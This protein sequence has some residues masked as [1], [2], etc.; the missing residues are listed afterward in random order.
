M[1]LVVLVGQDDTNLNVIFG[2]GLIQVED[3]ESYIWLLT[4]MKLAVGKVLQYTQCIFVVH[5]W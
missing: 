2:F 3:I 4:H 5:I 1:P